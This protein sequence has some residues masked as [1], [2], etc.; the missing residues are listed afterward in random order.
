M[1]ST[2]T[3][4]TPV[5]RIRGYCLQQREKKNKSLLEKKIKLIN[6]AYV[7]YGDV[8]PCGSHTDLMQCFT[9]STGYLYFWYNVGRDN[10]LSKCAI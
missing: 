6:D 2:I 3:P 4:I 10:H 1:I 5:N 9:I 7:L 8:Q